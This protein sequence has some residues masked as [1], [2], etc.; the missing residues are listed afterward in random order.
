MTIQMT[1]FFVDGGSKPNPGP[2][3]WVYIDAIDG[4]DHRVGIVEY[5][6]NNEMELRGIKEVLAHHPDVNLV[7][8]SDSEYALNAIAGK[9]Y[10]TA[11]RSLVLDIRE[12]IVERK[13]EGLSTELMWIPRNQN[14]A[15][16]IC[17]IAIKKAVDKYG[18]KV[19]PDKPKS[20]ELFIRRW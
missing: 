1:F 4:S 16:G 15:D 14:E 13:L 8:L 18:R 7:I 12:I 17:K 20:K 11:N 2:S 9:I 3:A 6:T 5:A 10:A 19:D